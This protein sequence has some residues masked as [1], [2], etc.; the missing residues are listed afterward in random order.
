MLITIKDVAKK[1]DVSVSTVSRILNNLPGYSEETKHRVEKVIEEIGYQ[2]NAVARGLINRKTKTIGV[3]VPKVSDLFAS[4]VLAGIEDLAHE[5]DYSVMIC[6]TN[7]DGERTMKYLQTLYEKRVDGI[8]IVSQAITPDY[9][10][11]IEKMD[12][13]VVLIAT[14]SE[15]PLS[16]IKV[17]DYQAAYDATTYLLE[18]GHSRV[19]MIA[20]TK[21]DAISTIPRVKGFTDALNDVGITATSHMITYGYY[22][23]KSGIEG[24]IQLLKNYPSLTAV[25]CASDEMA[26]GALS[27]L[28]KKEIKVPEKISVIGYDN[29]ATAEKAVPPLNSLAQPLYEMGKASIRLLLNSSG[30][31]K[32]IYPHHIVE[33]ETV[34]S[35]NE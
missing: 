4:E 29:T 16:F 11:K 5:L 26:A 20:G 2:P 19:G 32:Q 15:Y 24:M 28:Y 25:F 8:I 27:L 1:A 3:L 7:F 14:Q 34:R 13:S 22:D 30:K 31:V 12:V 23:F 33:R 10:R 18:K 21:G 9:Y 17:N 35:L 6:K